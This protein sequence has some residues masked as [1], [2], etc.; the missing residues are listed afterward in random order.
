M[1]YD[2]YGNYYASARD[3]HN[4]EMAQCAEIDARNA[5]EKVRNLERQMSHIQPSQTDYEITILQQ[6]IQNLEERIS[7]LENKLINQ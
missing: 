7:I 3:A 2:L 1:P 5:Y 6:H 4:A